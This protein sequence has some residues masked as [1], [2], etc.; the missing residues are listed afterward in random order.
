[1]LRLQKNICKQCRKEHAQHSQIGLNEKKPKDNEIFINRIKI[2]EK[3]DD[4]NIFKKFA[5]KI[6]LYL[7]CKNY[8]SF[9]S[10]FSSKFFNFNCS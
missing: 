3:F 7:F 10:L 4:S 1:M 5:K 9:Y 2:R 6:S 8:L